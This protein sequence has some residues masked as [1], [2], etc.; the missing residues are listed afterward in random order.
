MRVCPI[1]RLVVIYINLCVCHQVTLKGENT[2]QVVHDDQVKGLLRVSVPS[3][4]VACYHG[5][6]TV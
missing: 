4:C 5:D 6:R 1:K 3:P 2:S